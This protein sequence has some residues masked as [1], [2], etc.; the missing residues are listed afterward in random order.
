MRVD[1]CHA[2]LNE[3]LLQRL[4]LAAPLL[5]AK[6]L[7]LTV[8]EWDGTRC[9]LLVADARDGYGVNVLNIGARR[10]IPLLYFVDPDGG[11]PA[12]DGQWLTAAGCTPLAL[13]EALHR[14]LDTHAKATKTATAHPDHPPG[15]HGSVALMRADEPQAALVQLASDPRLAGQAVEASVHRRRVWVN[16]QDSRAYA[17]TLSDLLSTGECLGQGGWAFTPSAAAQATAPGEVSVS[18]DAY[19]LRGALRTPAPLPQFP[20]GHYRLRDWPD[21]GDAADQLGALRMAGLLTRGAM[22]PEAIGRDCQMSAEEVS[23]CLWAFHASALLQRVDGD[24]L[25][26][27]LVAQEPRGGLWKRIAERFG[28]A[29]T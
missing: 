14:L 4:R 21:L 6:R 19:Y 5:A 20:T 27:M 13:A 16:P 15:S 18:L 1:V 22:T 25:P 26:V 29:R 23:A 28:L 12:F 9:G 3:F 8:R 11:V 24:A 10:A 7:K 2:G 17:M